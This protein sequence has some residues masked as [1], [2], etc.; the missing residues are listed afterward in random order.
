MLTIR[1]SQLSAPTKKHEFALNPPTAATYS[2][3]T[4]TAKS[5]FI[6]VYE[7]IDKPLPAVV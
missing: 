2:I 4:E 6:E 7:E 5:G 1:T 3:T